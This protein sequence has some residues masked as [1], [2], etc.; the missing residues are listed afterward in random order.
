MQMSW[1]AFGSPRVPHLGSLKRKHPAVQ[2]DMKPFRKVEDLKRCTKNTRVSSSPQK[3]GAVA[4]GD[5][6]DGGF[7][8]RLHQVLHSSDS[9]HVAN[10]RPSAILSEGGLPENGNLG[11]LARLESAGGGGGGWGM[12]G[13]RPSH[14]F[15]A[16]HRK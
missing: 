9:R 6:H 16:G 8:L 12:G 4:H 2:F 11:P 15:N 7:Y 3:L 10:P 14:V 1:N 5:T 13:L